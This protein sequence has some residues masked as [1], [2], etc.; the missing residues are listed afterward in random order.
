[1]SFIPK[2]LTGVPVLKADERLELVRGDDRTDSGDR[3]DDLER[4]ARFD[5][6]DKGLLREWLALAAERQMQ[7]TVAHQIDTLFDTFDRM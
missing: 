2:N 6:H 1:M 3:L 7:S 4:R 5:K